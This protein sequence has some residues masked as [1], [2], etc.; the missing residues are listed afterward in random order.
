M[1]DFFQ[2]G[3]VMMWPMSLVGLAILFLAVHAAVLLARREPE[4]EGRLRAVLFWGVMSLVLGVLG[5]TVGIVQM[6]EA[7]ARSGGVRVTTLLGGFGVSLITSIFGLLI[8][9]VAAM[10]WF[11]LRQWHLRQAAPVRS[12]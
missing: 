7:V 1:A 2:G 10:L 5:T 9:L 6:A 11:A 12:A 8:F 4:V 3:G